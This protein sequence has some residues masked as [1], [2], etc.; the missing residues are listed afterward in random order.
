M[1]PV[2]AG[3]LRALAGLVVGAVAAALALAAALAA[4]GHTS[5]TLSPA[6]AALLALG[7]AS[8]STATI[9]AT[10]GLRPPTFALT[11]AIATSW[12]AAGLPLWCAVPA[13]LVTGIVIALDHRVRTGALIRGEK[14]VA[15]LGIAAA[16]LL[17]GAAATA[18]THELPP[19]KPPAVRQATP[20]L[21]QD[22]T[23]APRGGADAT[24]KGT[25]AATAPTPAPEHGNPLTGTDGPETNAGTDA[26]A[27]TPG[28]DAPGAR[29]GTDAPETSAGTDAEAA[30]APAPEH[31]NPAEGT[32]APGTDSATTAPGEAP[33]A[34]EPAVPAAEE[35]AVPAGGEARSE[36]VEF[37]RAYYTALDGRE[38]ATAWSRLSPAVK[39]RFGRFEKWRAG[40]ATT[41]A[42]TPEEITATPGADGSMAITHVLAAKDK[43]KC[44][45][46]LERR[47]KV[48]WRLVRSGSKWTATALSAT[49][50]GAPAKRAACG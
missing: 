14:P 22:A 32:D 16:L 49:A 43:T 42:S 41:L 7:F 10:G 6:C 21:G 38:F 1:T 26:P 15:A 24:A 2:A 23:A 9:V 50:I 37:V 36:A 17:A 33:A 40:Y 3:T 18:E 31:G 35:P 47:F 25:D 11:F 29:S 19:T 46:P 34:E 27:T 8:A 4:S 30:P 5:L 13:T 28:T 44:G 45:A 39:A 12:T 20:P 48:T